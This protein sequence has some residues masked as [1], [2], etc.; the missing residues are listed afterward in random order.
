LPGSH[1]GTALHHAAKKGLQ[2]T[3]HLLLSHGGNSDMKHFITLLF[4][5]VDL[6]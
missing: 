5:V 2:Q 6:Y 3:V 4:I 1:C